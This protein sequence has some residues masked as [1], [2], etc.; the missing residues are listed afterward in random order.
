MRKYEINLFNDDFKD[1][2]NALNTFEVEYILIGGYS[3]ILHGYSRTTGDLDIWVNKTEVNYRKME[4]AFNLF[5]IPADAIGINRFLN[6][7]EYD[8][9]SFGRSPV[10]IDIVTEIQGVEFEEAYKAIEKID[11]QGLEVNLIH[12][13]HLKQTKKATGRF[14]DLD[15]LENL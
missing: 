6:H 15:D 1:F 14:K 7:N 12:I 8:V 3:V 5:G 2:I 4:K 11:V 9:F 13:N 10:S